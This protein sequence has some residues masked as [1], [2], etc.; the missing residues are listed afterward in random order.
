MT[1]LEKLLESAKLT[2]SIVCFGIDPNIEKIP[3]HKIQLRGF[4]EY[5]ITNY[6]LDIFNEME[7]RNCFPS[8]IKFNEAYFLVADDPHHTNH[9]T[10]ALGELIYQIRTFPTFSKIPLIIDCKREDIGKSSKRYADYYFGKWKVDA[11]TISPYVG[12]KGIMP[13]LE[14]CT[15]DKGGYLLVKTS[16]E[17]ELQN[18]MLQ[19]GKKL[20]E[21]VCNWASELNQKYPGLGAV[22]SGKDPK[23]LELHLPYISHTLPLLIPGIGSQGGSEK[24]IAHI[25]AKTINPLQH[26]IAISSAIAYAYE[27]KNEPDKFAEHA[28]NALQIANGNIK[29]ELNGIL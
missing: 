9:G 6:Y 20:S 12:E 16:E 15:N 28:V 11:I 23:D 26:R 24:D 7:K 4:S 1:Y 8:A 2:K 22:F 5:K 10:N 17:S 13:F 19:D 29:G 21:W 27:S 14:Y 18:L 25:L 3:N